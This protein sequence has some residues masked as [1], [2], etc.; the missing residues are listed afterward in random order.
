MTK[1]Q[2]IQFLRDT[3]QTDPTARDL[4]HADKTRA[5]T[6]AESHFRGLNWDTAAKR[7][8]EEVRFGDLA[9]LFPK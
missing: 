2:R 9:R 6:L 5:A 1:D 3:I 8:I 4:S 7:G